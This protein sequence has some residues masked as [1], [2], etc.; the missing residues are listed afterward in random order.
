MNYQPK[1]K[2]VP[3]YRT[4]CIKCFLW[5]LL[6]LFAYVFILLIQLSLFNLVII[7]LVLRGILIL[8]R[9]ISVAEF[10]LDFTY[11]T[12]D[13]KKFIKDQN[14]KVYSNLGI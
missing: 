5:I 1:K 8:K 7:G 12:K 10:N 2:Q 11:K 14:A 3:C 9:L 4:C 6:I 13:F